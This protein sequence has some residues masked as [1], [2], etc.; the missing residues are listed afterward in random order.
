[1]LKGTSLRSHKLIVILWGQSKAKIDLVV[2]Y[3]INYFNIYIIEFKIK[4]YSIMKPFI[5]IL[6]HHIFFN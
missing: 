6:I 2:H 4:F 1:M 5:R 3:S